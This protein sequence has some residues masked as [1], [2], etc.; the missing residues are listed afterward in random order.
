[1]PWP[2][3]TDKR[4]LLMMLSLANIPYE[5]AGA[6]VAVN[7]NRIPPTRVVMFEFDGDG[8]LMDIYVVQR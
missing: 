5:D 4:L 8:S 7:R 2:K 1:M 6:H 3:M